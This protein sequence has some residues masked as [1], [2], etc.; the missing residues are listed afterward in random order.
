[1]TAAL[2]Q[3]RQHDDPFD[4]LARE[5]RA[6]ERKAD[7]ARKRYAA[8]LAA[9]DMRHAVEA[10]AAEDAERTHA[11]PCRCPRPWGDPRERRWLRCG[12]EAATR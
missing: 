12:R 6:A 8:T 11:T 7:L 5:L 2:E 9:L 4:D 10:L 3:D 1:M